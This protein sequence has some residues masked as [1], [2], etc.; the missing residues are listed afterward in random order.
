[1]NKFTLFII[2]IILYILCDAPYLL[3]NSTHY[4][5]IV[6]KIQCGRR[7]I[8]SRYYSALMVYV[9]LAIGMLTLVIS[10]SETP[11]D[12]LYYGALLGLVSYGVF[13]F[14]IHFMLEDYDLKTTIMDVIWGS[15]LS[16]FVAWITFTISK[17]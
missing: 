14:T 7:G 13:D 9:V 4:N 16:A 8:T 15:V 10:R 1:M 11:R 12:A 6:S 17:K 2:I 3:Y 5:L